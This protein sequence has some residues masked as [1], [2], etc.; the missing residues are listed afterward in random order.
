MYTLN[1]KLYIH[2]Q[3]LK[4]AGTILVNFSITQFLIT[5]KVN[6]PH[7]PAI[8]MSTAYRN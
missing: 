1:N 5:V 3:H 6:K 7:R 2:W 8:N 4:H